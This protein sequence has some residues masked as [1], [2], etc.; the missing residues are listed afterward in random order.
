MVKPIFP[1]LFFLL[2][3]E[4]TR[5]AQPT[6]PAPAA[7]I[8][9]QC[10]MKFWRKKLFASNLQTEKFNISQCEGALNWRQP[11]PPSPCHNHTRLA[12]PTP[13]ITSP[14]IVF[15]QRCVCWALARHWR[16]VCCTSHVPH[17]LGCPYDELFS[18]KI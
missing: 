14:K 2:F 1:L 17:P 8:T 3:V 15:H 16:Y 12:Q 5:R 18:Y 10:K 13:N 11:T 9:H 6:T 4:Q 7:T